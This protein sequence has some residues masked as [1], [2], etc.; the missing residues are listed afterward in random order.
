MCARRRS[1]FS[2][3]VQRKGTKRK[4][5]PALA[6]LRR[7]P[8][9]AQVRKAPAELAPA[10]LKQSSG[11]VRPIGLTATF[12]TFRSSASLRGPRNQVD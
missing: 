8:G 4:D 1:P 5:T 7:V 3:L 6:R 9:G 12:Q 2:L 10:G 11:A